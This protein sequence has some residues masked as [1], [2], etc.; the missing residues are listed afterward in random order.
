LLAEHLREV[1]TIVR[2]SRG[3]VAAAATRGPARTRRLR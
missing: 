2:E 3:K 1:Y